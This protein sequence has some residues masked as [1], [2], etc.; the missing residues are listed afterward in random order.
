LRPDRGRRAGRLQ[1]DLGVT[2]PEPLPADHPF[3]D[4]PGVFITPHV[5]AATPVSGA[6]AVDFVR[7]RAHRFRAGEPL[8]NVITGDY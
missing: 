7:A 4:M 8:A 1:A 5:A 6:T 3:W 2:G